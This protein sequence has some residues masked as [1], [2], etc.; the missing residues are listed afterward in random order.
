MSAL[1]C[2]RSWEAEAIEDGRLAGSSRESFDRH[3]RGCADCAREVAALAKLRIA[4][5][6]RP[7]ATRTE[8]EH[9]RARI[10]L[11]KGANEAV[12]RAPSR[13]RVAP[14]YAAAA[15]AFLV[16][17]AGWSA[18][19]HSAYPASLPAPTYEIDASTP[20]S[21][22]VQ[23]RG[24]VT[25]LALTEGH[26]SVH[27]QHLGPGQRFLAALPDGTLEVRG[28]RFTVE[29]HGGRTQRVEVDEGSVALRL[30]EEPERMLRAGDSFE[31]DP[32]P[33]LAIASACAPAAEVTTP[34]AARSA[35]IAARPR[36]VAARPAASTSVSAISSARPPS[37]Y[38]RAMEAFAA[39]RYEEADALFAA[40]LGS[41]GGDARCE[42]ALFLRAL[43]RARS[44]D[45]AG[46]S[47]LAKEYLATYPSGLRRA[48]AER[49]VH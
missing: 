43:C 31:R 35:T 39:R 8:L 11:L 9:R 5:S 45:D 36:P 22:R 2:A 28:T 46:A 3:A 38:A 13:R 33:P 23:L 4:S 26:T 18:L 30:R 24:P 14:L 20:G 21:Y 7:A 37:G 27:V 44:G 40:F 25:I 42:D 34:I 12:V 48:D 19:H 47:R 16:G 17:A 32:A 29:I 10:A 6:S 15:V 1:R 41:F 49:L